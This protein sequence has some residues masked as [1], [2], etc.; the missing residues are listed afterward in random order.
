MT[1]NNRGTILVVDDDQSILQTISIL[2]KKHGYRPVV[3]NSAEDAIT[4]LKENSYDAVMADIKMPDM[5]GLQLLDMIRNFNSEIPVIMMTAFADFYAAVDAIKLKAFDFIIKPYENKH[6]LHSVEKAVYYYRLIISEKDYKLKLEESVEE[7]TRELALTIEALKNASR[8]MMQRLAMISE[9]R[10]TDTGPHIRRIGM[11]SQKISEALNMSKDFINTISFASTLH[12]IGKVGIPDSVLLKPGN[13]TSEEFETIMTH[14]TI[15]MKMLS[16]STY[17]GIQ[18]AASIALTHHEKWNG[19]GY[20]K[21]LSGEQIPIEGR[22]VF[23]V[24]RYD[25]IRSKRPYKPPIDHQRAVRIMKEGQGKSN[26]EHYDPMV[27]DAFIKVSPTF[28]K[29]FNLI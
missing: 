7:K 29:I 21:G 24:D 20:P 16:G 12:D 25:A 10:D 6:I 9:F 5:S 14:T 28:E 4:R 1:H 18:M 15:G 19:K 8:E 3:S 17:P 26:P 11:Y 2:L 27:L 23:L 22:I 13:L